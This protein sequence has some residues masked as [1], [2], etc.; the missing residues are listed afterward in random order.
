MVRATLVE[1]KRVGAVDFFFIG[2]DLN[3][4]LTLCLD[5]QIFQLHCDQHL[6]EQ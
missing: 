2:G 1:G 6:D 3:I 4:E 5:E